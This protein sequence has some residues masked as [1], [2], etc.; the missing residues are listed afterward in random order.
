MMAFAVSNAVVRAGAGAARGPARTAAGAAAAARRARW[1]PTSGCSPASCSPRRSPSCSSR[2]RCSAS[3]CRRRGRWCAARGRTS[4]PPRRLPTAYAFDAA[5]NTRDLR[6]RPDDRGRA[7]AGAARR[8]RGRDH[9]RAE[10]DRA[11]RWWRWPRRSAAAGAG[12][13]RARRGLLG[14]LADGRIRLLL[15]MVVLDTFAFGCL[16]VTAVA[17]ASGQGFAGVFTSL[18]AL[19]AVVSGI[20]Y[21]ARHWPGGRADAAAR[22]ARRRGAGAGRRRARGAGRRRPGVDRRRVPR[23]A[24]CHRS[25]GD[26][27]AGAHRRGQARPRNGSR[28]SRGCSA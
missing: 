15:G 2:P 3:P 7:A 12:R 21:G 19:G 27:A 24:A 17:A 14:P 26:R 23:R 1:W 11:T 10:G 13:R 8:G 18:L 25:G 16:E 5:L 22:A 6:V 28:R 20:A 9:R 4:C